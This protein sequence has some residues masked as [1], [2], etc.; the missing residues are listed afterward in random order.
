M[1]DIKVKYFMAIYST[2]KLTINKLPYCKP[3]SNMSP[4]F[5]ATTCAFVFVDNVF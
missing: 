1:L 5:K 3:K 2:S 4:K